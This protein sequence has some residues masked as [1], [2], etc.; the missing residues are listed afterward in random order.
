MRIFPVVAEMCHILQNT[1]TVT[2]LP[3]GASLQLLSYTNGMGHADDFCM[4]S[5]NTRT[6]ATDMLYNTTNGQAHNKL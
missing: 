3:H 2:T 1:V 6:P 4:L 5:A